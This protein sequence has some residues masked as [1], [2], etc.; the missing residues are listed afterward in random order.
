MWFTTDMHSNYL[1]ILWNF[2]TSTSKWIKSYI[3]MN[4]QSVRQYRPSIHILKAL[5]K[6]FLIKK[7][8]LFDKEPWSNLT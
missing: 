5:C 4:E 3:N 7:M 8:L 1:E 6:L 2:I